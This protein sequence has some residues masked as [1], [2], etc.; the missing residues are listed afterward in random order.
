MSSNNKISIEEIEDNLREQ[1]CYYISCDQILS[2]AGKSK[3]E[4]NKLKNF[5][6]ES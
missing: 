3:K 5:Q 6:N 2:R 4:E 1:N